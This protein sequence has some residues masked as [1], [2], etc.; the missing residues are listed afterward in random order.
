MAEKYFFILD[1]TKELRNEDQ[2]DTVYSC[3]VDGCVEI[4]DIFIH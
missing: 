4:S 2:R 3:N 1:P